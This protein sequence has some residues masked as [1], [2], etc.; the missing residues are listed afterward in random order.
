[1]AAASPAPH[2]ARAARQE[3]RLPAD[4]SQAVPEP[5]RVEPVW[6]QDHDREHADRGRREPVWADP[7]LRQERWANEDCH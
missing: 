7:T 5:G 1:M 3:P 6:G 4:W 2:A